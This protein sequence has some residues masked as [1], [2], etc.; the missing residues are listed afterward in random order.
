MNY[1]MSR[2]EFQEIEDLRFWIRLLFYSSL[3]ILLPL[4]LPRH[5]VSYEPHLASVAL[6]NVESSKTIAQV[7]FDMNDTQSARWPNTHPSQDWTNGVCDTLVGDD[8]EYFDH[9]VTLCMLLPLGD[10]AYFAA[11]G[12]QCILCYHWVTLNNLLTL[13]NIAYFVAIG[14]TVFFATIGW[15]CI[16]HCH[17]VTLNTWLPLENGVTLTG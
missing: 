13:G 7:L 16:L 1:I 17:W 11:I 10:S 4:L 3:T 2:E 12:W 14:D 5:L 8:I 9:W 6:S 15:Q